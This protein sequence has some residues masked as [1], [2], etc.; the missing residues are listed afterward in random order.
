MIEYCPLP[1]NVHLASPHTMNETRPSGPVSHRSYALMYHCECIQ[2]LKT[3][4]QDEFIAANERQVDMP[5]L[6]SVTD[7]GGRFQLDEEDMHQ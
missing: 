5:N 7:E 3:G 6:T 4:K 2:N 1:L